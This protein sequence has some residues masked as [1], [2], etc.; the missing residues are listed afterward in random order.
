MASK[1]SVAIG[2]D[3]GHDE[4]RLFRLHKLQ[5]GVRIAHVDDAGMVC[6]LMDGGVRV[7]IH[8]D[9]FHAQA[10]Q[11][12]DDF[13]PSSPAPS[14]MTRVAEGCRGCQDA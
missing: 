9:D 1:A 14:S 4:L 10:L 2:L 13:L 5:Q 7:A 8:S 3:F 11:R 12:D 6:D